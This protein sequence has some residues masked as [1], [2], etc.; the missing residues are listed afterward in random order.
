[1]VHEGEGWVFEVDCNGS[2]NTAETAYYLRYHTYNT[3]L[4]DII[5]NNILQYSS[6]GYFHVLGACVVIEGLY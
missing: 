3:V 6:L 1:M 2:H 4:H 5:I